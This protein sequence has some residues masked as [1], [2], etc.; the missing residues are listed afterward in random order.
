ML[1]DK[2]RRQLRQEAEHW[3]TEGLIDNSVYEQIS[4]RYKFND[5]EASAS[6]RFIIIL[7]GLGSV[8]LGLGIITFVAAN[9]QEWSR[10]LKVTLLLSGFI[11]INTAGFYLWRHPIERWQSR[12]GQ[13]L[14]LLGALAL[15]ANMALM[16]QMFHQS[17]QAYQLYL[18]WG[19]GVLAM[20]YSLRMTMLGVLAV[21]LVGFGYL[22]YLWGQPEPI[23]LGG[24]SW[25]QLFVQHMPVVA[26]LMF[27]PLA[28]WC[29]SRWIFRISAIAII[30]SLEA[31]IIRFNLLGSSPWMAAIACALPPALLWAYRDSFVRRQTPHL[32]IFSSIARSLALTFL[33]LLFYVL[34][35][36]GVWTTSLVRSP[37]DALPLFLPPFVDILLLSGL[38]LLQWV[39]LLRR[40]D[41]T[42]YFVAGMIV[43]SAIVPVWHLNS[44]GHAVFAVLIFNLLL[45]FL[46]LGLIR[47]GLAQGQRR[48]FWGG[49]VLLTLQIFSRMLEYDTDLL[50]KSLVLFLCGLGVMAGGLWFERYLRT[51]SQ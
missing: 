10:E 49:M 39:L 43:I 33:S 27:V 15:G 25:L 3:H 12:L 14:L 20:A 19:L 41:V 50:F 2:F 26:S 9:W 38:T 35:F 46:A 30:F 4:D 32:E 28:Y 45:F 40:Q 42:T 51:R 36:Y 1:S 8:F 48:L 6:N 22:R 21:L 23:T 24:L 5:L 44:S 34:S 11:S 29:G 31:N 47:E 37:N 16:S 17:G 13:A 18:V 7:L